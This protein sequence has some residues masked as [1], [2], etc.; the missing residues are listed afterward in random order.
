MGEIGHLLTPPYPYPPILSR[1]SRLPLHCDLLKQFDH[2]AYLRTPS[3]PLLKLVNQ[4]GPSPMLAIQLLQTK[5][6]VHGLSA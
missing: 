4:Q 3:T 6:L 2:R 1:D 5:R